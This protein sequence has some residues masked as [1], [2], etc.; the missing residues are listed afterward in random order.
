MN[1]Y[2][3]FDS[4]EKIPYPQTMQILWWQ[5]GTGQASI[6][7]AITII[8][9]PDEDPENPIMQYLRFSYPVMEE[10]ELLNLMMKFKE[11]KC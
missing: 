4:P 9:E 7:H 11:D 5:D 2:I 10:S 6:F 8:E 1:E 3:D